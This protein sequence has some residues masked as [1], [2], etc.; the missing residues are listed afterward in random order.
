MIVPD[1]D[2]LVYAY[3]EGTYQHNNARQWWEEL[4]NGRE[5]IGIP[6]AVATGFVRIM[7]NPTAM[8][9][10]VQ[11]SQ[12]IDVVKAWYS[13]SHI[14]PLNPGILHLQFLRQAL[15]ES[16]DSAGVAAA[17]RVPDAHIAAL[18]LEQDAEVHTTDTGFA[19]YSGLRWRNPL[20]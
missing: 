20:D 17:N 16:G 7:A 18:A 10:P 13:Y 1:V 14:R 19:R 3:R 9:I 2:L 5:D 8:T 11:P 6:W 12:T 4:V 15:V